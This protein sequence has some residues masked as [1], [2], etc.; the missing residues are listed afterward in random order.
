M[1]CVLFP[2]VVFIIANYGGA[3]RFVNLRYHGTDTASMM[4]LR[5]GLSTKDALGYALEVRLLPASGFN[6]HTT[7]C[8]AYHQDFEAQT[9]REFGF[10]LSGRP[11]AVDDVRVRGT[12][13]LVNGL[14][15]CATALTHHWV[16]GVGLSSTSVSSPSIP[17]VSP[18]LPDPVATRQVCVDVIWP[19]QR[20]MW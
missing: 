3:H 9:L 4:A 6:L 1:G 14:E 11:V 7:C 5:P 18:D 19:R 10:K 17:E 8:A 16:S 13:V 15:L 12:C 2:L 20:C